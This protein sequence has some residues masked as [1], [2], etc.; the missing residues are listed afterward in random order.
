MLTD[1]ADAGDYTGCE[2]FAAEGNEPKKRLVTGYVV[3]LR[4]NRPLS[5]GEDEPEAWLGMREVDDGHPEG[6]TL[7]PCVVSKWEA[8]HR[9]HNPGEITAVLNR[10]KDEFYAR[11]WPTTVAEEG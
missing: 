6:P 5:S 7:R 8:A 11:Y 9:F 4:P 2:P 1:D 10:M 3:E